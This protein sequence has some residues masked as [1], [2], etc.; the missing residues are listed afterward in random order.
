MNG[1]LLVFFYSIGFLLH[2]ISF[3]FI[4]DN[5]LGDV[6]LSLYA[7]KIIKQKL[8]DQNKFSQNI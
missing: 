5:G 3:F 1:H 8:N 6:V 7:K 2:F 4:T